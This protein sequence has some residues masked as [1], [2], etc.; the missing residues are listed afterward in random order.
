VLSENI[1]MQRAIGQE[2]REFELCGRTNATTLPMII[3]Y[4]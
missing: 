2:I 4:P 3:H 1:D